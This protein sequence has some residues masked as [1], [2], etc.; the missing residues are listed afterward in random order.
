MPEEKKIIIRSTNTYCP[1]CGAI[2]KVSDK[3]CSQCGKQLE[4]KEEGKK[5]ET[6][7]EFKAVDL[8]TKARKKKRK[9]VALT[10]ILILMGLAIG[11]WLFYA[12]YYL[13]YQAQRDYRNKVENVWEVILEKSNTFKERLATVNSENDINE[14]NNDSQDLENLLTEK[15]NEV[16]SWSLNGNFNEARGKF[17]TALENYKIYH[18][19]LQKNILNKNLARVKIT[20]DF[21]KVQKFANLANDSLQDFYDAHDFIK[22]HLSEKVFDLSELR[23]FIKKWQGEKAVEEKSKLEEEKAAQEAAEKRAVEGV[24][25]NFMSNLPNA[26]S[27]PSDQQWSRAQAIADKYWYTPSMSNFVGDY[28]TYFEEGGF[29]KYVGGQVIKSEKLSNTKYDVTAEERQ[30]YTTPQGDVEH[31]YLSYFIVEK[32]GNYGWFITSHGKR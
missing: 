26:Y 14:L 13:P 6:R 21:A 3:F 2:V 30:K 9:L 12:Y 32:I 20:T 22:E 15:I 11:G 19:E 10:I 16:E 1:S 24:V 17:K 7:A 18:H 23:N 25:L 27:A 4:E 5:E 29:T 28:Q 31:K 8:E